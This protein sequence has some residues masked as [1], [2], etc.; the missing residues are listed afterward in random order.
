MLLYYG[1][2]TIPDSSRER[3]GEFVD[4]KA[5]AEFRL[6][7]GGFRRLRFFGVVRV[8]G[9]QAELRGRH[10]LWCRHIALLSV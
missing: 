8:S 7:P 4:G 1:I 6:E 10:L 5:A 9:R 2:W 3:S